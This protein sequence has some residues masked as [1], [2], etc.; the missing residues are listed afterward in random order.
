MRNHGWS[1]FQREVNR[2]ATVRVAAACRRLGSMQA[3]TVRLAAA[4]LR[5]RHADVGL[6]ERRPL[7]LVVFVGGGGS[8]GE[9]L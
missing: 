5:A 1:G 7:V 2:A 3:C 4:C 9:G 6:H 8:G